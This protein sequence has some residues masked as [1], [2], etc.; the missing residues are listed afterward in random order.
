MAKRYR[1]S[2]TKKKEAAKGKLSVALALSSF[3]LFLGAVLAYFLLEGEMGFV[4]GGISLFAMLLSIYG[5]I[6]GLV[7]FSE[8]KRLHRTSIIGSIANGVIMVGWLA[9]YLMGVQ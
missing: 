6:M 2:F 7:S 3:L 5:F 9:F 4:V 1:Y 8:E